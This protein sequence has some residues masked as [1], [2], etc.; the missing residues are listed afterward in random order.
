MNE[1]ILGNTKLFTWNWLVDQD[2]SLVA[3]IHYDRPFR[4][5]LKL[6]YQYRQTDILVTNNIFANVT[7]KIIFQIKFR[8]LA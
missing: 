6:K 3:Y 5:T 4:K 8:S 7:A 2:V 1:M